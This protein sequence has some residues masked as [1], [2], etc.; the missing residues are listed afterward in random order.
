MDTISKLKK[1]LH[2]AAHFKILNL[3][4]KSTGPIYRSSNVIPYIN[5]SDSICKDQI[6]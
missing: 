3:I 4:R 6:M 2:K 1:S 5:T